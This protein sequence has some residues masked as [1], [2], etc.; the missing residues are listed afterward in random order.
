MTVNTSPQNFVSVLDLE[1]TILSNERRDSLEFIQGL[2]AFAIPR[3]GFVIPGIMKL[4][5][6]MSYNIGINA[7]YG[8]EAV[9]RFGLAAGV[10]N[11][12][13]VST[14]VHSPNSSVASGFNG[15][16]TPIF[17]IKKITSGVSLEAFAQPQ[18]AFGFQ[19]IAVCNLDIAVTM[20]LPGISSTLSVEEGM[21]ERH[22]H[23]LHTTLN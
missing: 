12:A 10:P 7:S 18:L 22:P 20:K 16:L 2:E 14:D 15:M 4:G 3:A 1:A 5:A 17:D 11:N 19:L 13:S 8:G 23:F 21:F 6:T 9:I